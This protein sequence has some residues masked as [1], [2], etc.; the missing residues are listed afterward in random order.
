M[1]TKKLKRYRF[2]TFKFYNDIKGNVFIDFYKYR[3]ENNHL[4][5]FVF[6]HYQLE[7]YIFGNLLKT[8]KRGKK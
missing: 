3:R 2:I 7:I 6:W 8:K 1:E 5:S 4:F